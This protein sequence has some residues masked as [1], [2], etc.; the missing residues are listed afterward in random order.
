MAVTLEGRMHDRSFLSPCA[1]CTVAHCRGEFAL[2]PL[3]F[4]PI[5]FTA[6]EQDVPFHQHPRAHVSFVVRGRVR[7]TLRKGGVE[8]TR[9]Y[10]AG[11]VETCLIH[12]PAG[13]EHRFVALTAD[14]ITACVFAHYDRHGNPS[15]DYSPAGEE[16]YI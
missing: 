7:A 3:F 16:A 12:V 8:E 11:A 4:R 13:V 15:Q 5:K 2:G 1:S 10:E 14:A 6:V 9:D